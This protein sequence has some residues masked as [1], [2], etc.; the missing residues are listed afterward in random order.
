MQCVDLGCS[1][2]SPLPK[3]A[4][5]SLFSQPVFCSASLTRGIFT[6]PH[7]HQ[8][9]NERQHQAM[10][11]GQDTEDSTSNKR[12][13]VQAERVLSKR[14]NEHFPH[15]E[16]PLQS[17]RLSAWT[18]I[19]YA[20]PSFSTTPCSVLISV[21]LVPFY[22]TVGAQLAYIAFFVALAR[23]FD[24][25]TDPLMSYFTDAF[26]SK[27]GRRRPFMITGAF[28]PYG[29]LFM[30]L[31]MP[32]LAGMQPAQTCILGYCMCYFSWWARTRT[33]HTTPLR[34]SLLTITRTEQMSFS[35]ARSLMAWVA[36]R[37]W[38]ACWVDVLTIAGKVV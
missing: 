24:V 5:Y 23:S 26:R 20:A 19:S 34:L 7:A 21:Y 15:V 2:V 1:N 18:Y 38:R 33:F 4:I 32:P 30:L 28:L 29:L 36:C 3:R 9:T 6:L 14:R 10:E 12:L 37:R 16:G 25:L 8:I 13:S 31:C 22:E 17:G 11:G 27:W 35:F